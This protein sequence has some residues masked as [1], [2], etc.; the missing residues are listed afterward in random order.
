MSQV[1]Q[2]PVKVEDEKESAYDSNLP[3]TDLHNQEEEHN[4]LMISLYQ[5]EYR[6]IAR[7][8]FAQGHELCAISF[9]EHMYIVLILCIFLNYVI[10]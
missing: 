9:H 4:S 7:V 2:F 3:A 1:L 6:L 5:L 10:N 8:Q